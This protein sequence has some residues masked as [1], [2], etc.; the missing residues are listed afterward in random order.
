MPL[1][2]TRRRQEI[3]PA[4]ILGLTDDDLWRLWS[5]VVPD[6][7]TPLL[8]G[9]HCWTWRGGHVG[10]GYP[11]M[12]LHRQTVCVHRLMCALAYGLFASMRILA[13]HA[14][15]NRGC[16]NPYHLAPGDHG[17]NLRHA[18]ART[19]RRRPATFLA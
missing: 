18:W 13:M 11:A 9:Q 3:A 15:D 16:V 14:C 8:A 7:S 2:M 12:Y 6:E 10:E 4:I 1:T 17:T 19:R 5:R